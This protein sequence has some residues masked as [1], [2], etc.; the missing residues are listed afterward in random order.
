MEWDT[1]SYMKKKINK[2]I[3]LV[4]PMHTNFIFVF[5]FLYYLAVSPSTKFSYTLHGALLVI[6]AVMF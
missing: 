1:S 5:F 6:T 2:D 3:K 4:L